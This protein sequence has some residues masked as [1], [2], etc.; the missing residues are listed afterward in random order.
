MRDFRH[1]EIQLPQLR[2]VT[3]MNR[4]RKTAQAGVVL[5]LSICFSVAQEPKPRSL[6]QQLFQAVFN[7]DTIS[8]ERLL[9]DG[10]NVEA[11][12]Q[13][14]ETAL[15]IAAE[16]GQPAI[17][18][19]LLER[20]ANAEAKDQSEDTALVLAVRGG[21][22]EVIET[23]VPNASSQD[24]RQALFAAID[25]GAI[26]VIQIEAPEGDANTPATREPSAE[27]PETKIVKLLLDN[28][29]GLEARREDS[30][31]PLIWASA[32][33]NTEA[34][35]LLL[36]KGAD[37]GGRESDGSTALIAAACNCA[38]ATMPPT[39]DAMELLLEKGA[40]I[41]AKAND[42]STALISAAG[43]G[44]T[45]NV[46]LLLDHGARIEAR[47]KDGNTALLVA[48]KG[49]AYATADAVKLLLDRKANVGAKNRAGQT[50]LMLA[51]SGGGYDAI[52][53]VRS[54]LDHGADLNAKDPSGK[55]AAALALKSGHPDIAKLLNSFK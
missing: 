13:N 34:V 25:A 37:V 40:D 5:T 31:T 48:A 27:L 43:A 17:V 10:A 35:K 11:S 6:D 14:G 16:S 18:K 7:W 2:I 55:T 1:F 44:V 39:D 51:A 3:A 54:L 19:L 32:L 52:D 28:G 30:V 49:S 38:M 29:A 33:G 8:A 45:Y 53:S 41:E 36:E 23:L 20:G 12:D 50:A 22:P 15:M 26:P 21:N 42:G 47:D 46:K 24:K 4:M 9:R